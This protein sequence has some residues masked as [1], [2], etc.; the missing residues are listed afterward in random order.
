MFVVLFGP[1]KSSYVF[2]AFLGDPS[3]PTVPEKA[4]ASL[5]HWRH[6]VS[7]AQ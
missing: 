3:L 5:S 2:G 7:S 6:F 4:K 1:A